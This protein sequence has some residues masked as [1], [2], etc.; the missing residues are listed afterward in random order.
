MKIPTSYVTYSEFCKDPFKGKILD[1]GCGNKKLPSSIGLDSVKLPFEDETFDTIICNSIIEHVDNI[2][3][4][5]KEL[6]RILKKGGNIYIH[7]PYWKAPAAAAD[8]THKQLLNYYSFDFVTEEYQFPYYVNYKL[9]CTAY[10]KIISTDR[11]IKYILRPIEIII[12]KFPNFYEHFL[13]GII[14]IFNVHY[15]LTKK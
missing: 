10:L 2:I 14:P 7:V 12:N 13:S 9:T 8:V 3:P 5:I 6:F 1:L 15:R 11:P 4:V